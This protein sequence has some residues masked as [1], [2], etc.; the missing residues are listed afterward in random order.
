MNND[1]LKPTKELKNYLERQSEAAYQQL[2]LLY[3]AMIIKAMY[4]EHQNKVML[5]I[6]NEMTLYDDQILSDA[7][8]AVNT[9]CKLSP[10]DVAYA[11]VD[12]WEDGDWP[13]NIHKDSNK[14]VITF[15]SNDV[16]D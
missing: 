10:A 12:E 11:V 3:K 7:I 16:K 9:L 4:L 2:F 14:F 13:A 15:F 5:P 1:I 6:D 8:D